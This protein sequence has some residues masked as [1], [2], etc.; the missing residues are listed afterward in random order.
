MPHSALVALRKNPVIR[1]CELGLY[2]RVIFVTSRYFG[3]FSG[4]N[5]GAPVPYVAAAN[6]H[7]HGTQISLQHFKAGPARAR[8]PQLP[9][10]IVL[11][12]ARGLARAGAGRAHVHATS[13]G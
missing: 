4:Y 5:V 8:G 7:V 9:R 11:V 1:I 2:S 13:G 10:A 3:L 12:W 6:V